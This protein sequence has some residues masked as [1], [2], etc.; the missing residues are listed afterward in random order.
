M[1]VLSTEDLSLS[2]GSKKL[3]GGV[4]FAAD[5]YDKIGIIGSNGCGKTSLL[6]ILLDVY[7]ET[8]GEHRFGAN[9]DIGIF[10]RKSIAGYDKLFKGIYR[11]RTIRRGLFRTW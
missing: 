8:F 7:A 4:S 11:S 6:K 5:E 1:I 3:F 10:Q 9:I 2:F